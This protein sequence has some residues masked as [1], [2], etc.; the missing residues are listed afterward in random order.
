MIGAGEMREF[1]TRQVTSNV[2]KCV[3]QTCDCVAGR[4]RILGTVGRGIYD[5]DDITLSVSVVAERDS[6][7][8]GGPYSKIEIDLCPEC[9]RD[10]L[11]PWLNRR[12]PRCRSRRR[13]VVSDLA[14]R[15]REGA[16][17]VQ[18]RAGSQGGELAGEFELLARIHRRC[19][20]SREDL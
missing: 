17:Q 16:G 6:A 9:F 14:Y 13:S 8:G 1:E 5:V 20:W 4:R 7:I 15:R 19:S 2:T 3:R 10:R 18:G 12:E 11:I